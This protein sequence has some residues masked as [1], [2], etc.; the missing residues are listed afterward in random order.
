[1]EGPFIDWPAML[2]GLISRGM[3]G[4]AAEKL[5]FMWQYELYRAGFLANEWNDPVPEQGGPT[6]EAGDGKE[7]GDGLVPH[8]DGHKEQD[9]RNGR[10]P[11]R[12]RRLRT[13]E[14][15]R[16]GTMAKRRRT[17]GL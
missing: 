1:M 4:E 17:E 2:S 8:V 5:L 6:E 13:W 3:R 11:T 10:P 12:I 15:L 7:E 16:G 9:S 14:E